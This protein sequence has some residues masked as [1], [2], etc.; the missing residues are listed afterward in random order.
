M[1]NKELTSGKTN[2][3]CEF[4]TIYSLTIVVAL[5]IMS[6]IQYRINAADLEQPD[7]IAPANSTPIVAP[8]ADA[9]QL[10]SIHR[11]KNIIVNLSF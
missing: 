4:L 3:P 1:D 11:L 5:A 8:I 7:Q 6:L 9:D 2:R 10:F